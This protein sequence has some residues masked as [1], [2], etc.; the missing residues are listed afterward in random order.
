MKV[1]IET[2]TPERARLMLEF[3]KNN[4]PLIKR[5][6]D[7]LRSEM[8]NDRWI[9]NGESVKFSTT[10]ELLDGQHRLSSIVETGKTYEMVVVRD[11]SKE[12][13]KSLDT[14]RM[15][16]A[17]DVFSIEGILAANKVAAACREILSLQKGLLTRGKISNGELIEYLNENREIIEHT[18]EKNADYLAFGRI[19]PISVVSGMSWLMSQRNKNKSN[20]F[21]KRL[22]SGLHLEETNPIYLLRNML[23]ADKMS[24]RR[25][26]ISE[27]RG[28]IIK[29]WNYFLKEEEV[30]RLSFDVKNDKVPKI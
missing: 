6:M 11:L 10:G 12:A 24:K 2:V 18:E 23:Q 14:G 7:F 29:T 28:L 17:G 27:K 25:M 19:L 4:R 21:W 15:R 22:C 5:H 1:S 13:F 30:K 16:T 26:T 9:E 20:L 3:N 8:E